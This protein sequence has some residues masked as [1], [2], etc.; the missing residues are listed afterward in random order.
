MCILGC[1]DRLPFRGRAWRS[2][3]PAVRIRRR[4]DTSTNFDYNQLHLT[5]SRGLDAP[6]RAGRTAIAALQVPERR[7]QA[8][9]Q[10]LAK[11]RP[12]GFG[13]SSC[14]AASWPCAIA[15]PRRMPA[16]ARSWPPTAGAGR[17]HQGMRAPRRWW[18]LGMAWAGR[19]HR[20]MKAGGRWYPDQNQAQQTRTCAF[21]SQAGPLAAAWK[22]HRGPG[23]RHL[24]CRRCRQARI[25]ARRRRSDTGRVSR[26]A[27]LRA[28]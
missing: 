12:A 15:W 11:Q 6:F 21:F 8:A 27:A 20:R 26:G 4:C 22:C 2:A 5:S 28:L 9:T 3:A 14:A 17:R 1:C 16:G 10:S 7:G 24:S 19:C 23:G 18:R 25:L 13:A